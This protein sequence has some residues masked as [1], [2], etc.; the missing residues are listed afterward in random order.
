MPY[1]TIIRRVTTVHWAGLEVKKMKGGPLLAARD[2]ISKRCTSR[3]VQ[4]NLQDLY[5]ILC[6]LPIR[7]VSVDILIK[8]MVVVVE[9]FSGR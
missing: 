5:M 9:M 7:G 8:D 2:L 1:E 3:P 4:L 6:R